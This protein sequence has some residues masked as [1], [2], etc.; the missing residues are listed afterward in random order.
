MNCRQYGVACALLIW[1]PVFLAAMPDF[2]PDGRGGLDAGQIQQLEQGRIVFTVSGVADRRSELIEAAFL[3]DKPPSEVW[4]LLYRTEDQYLYLRE[5]ESSKVVYKSPARDLIEYRVRVF[6]VGTTFR[7]EHLYNWKALYMHWDLA[8]DFD[9]GLKDFKGF[10]RLYP[11]KD[12][13]TLARYGNRVSP[14]GIPQIV[15]DL[16]RKGGIVRALEAVRL[17]VESDGKYRK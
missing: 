15:M 6:L 16:F 3:L 8:P 14:S 9:S 2:G 10:W 1:F 4:E 7:L 12:G 11:Y 5:T 17:Y 13:R